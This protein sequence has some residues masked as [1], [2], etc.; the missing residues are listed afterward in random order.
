MQLSSTN[1][2]VS[3]QIIPKFS[4][5][6]AK[7]SDHDVILIHED[8]KIARYSGGR[9]DLIWDQNVS[10]VEDHGS[11]VV[12]AE[13]FNLKDAENGFLK[14]REDIW[15][16]LGISDHRKLQNSHQFRLLAIISHPIASALRPKISLF[17]LS[18]FGDGKDSHK[19]R[20]FEE[21]ST[22]TISSPLTPDSRTGIHYQLDMVSGTLQVLCNGTISSY[23]LAPLIPQK[24]SE[25]RHTDIPLTSF[26]TVSRT[27]LLGVSATHYGSYNT[28]YNSLL[29]S[30]PITK[31]DFLPSRKRKHDDASTTSTLNFVCYFFKLRLAVAVSGHELVGIP[32]DE[33]QKAHKRRK[34]ETLP[35]IDAI[36]KGL[37]SQAPN[38]SPVKSDDLFP[39]LRFPFEDS[40]ILPEYGKDWTDQ[41]GFFNHCVEQGDVDAFEYK[42]A[43]YVGMKAKIIKNKRKRSKDKHAQGVEKSSKVESKKKHILDIVPTGRCEWKFRKARPSRRMPQF[44]TQA[45]YALSKIFKPSTA[46]NNMSL[47]NGS[48][49][50]SGKLHLAFYAPNIFHWLVITGQLT[51]EFINQALRLDQN[52]SSGSTEIS[53]GDLVSAIVEFDPSLGLLYSV[54]NHHLHLDI[55]ML[56]H[57]TKYVIRS[58]DNSI[59]PQSPP[60]PNSNSNTQPPKEKPLTN[61][62]T[63]HVEEEETHELRSE[64]DAAM[65]EVD[66]ALSTLETGL[67]IRAESMRLALS[68]LSTFSKS[69]ITATLRS[70]L[71]QHE[72]ISFI[73][74]LR[75]QLADGGWTARYVDVD[76]EQ[77]DSDEPS[78]RAI[79]VICNLLGCTVDAIGIGGWLMST[80]SD[81][82]DAVDELLA[83]LRGEIATA[84]EGVHEATFM[85]GLLGEFMRYGWIREQA[86]PMSDI[87]NGAKF[88]KVQGDENPDGKILPMGFKVE[89][90]PEKTRVMSGGE[91][92]KRSKRD[93]AREINMA[94]GKYSFE[95]IRM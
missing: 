58:L 49:R 7:D 59:L 2:V 78:N 32:L 43:H 16:R 60:L 54:L 89:K 73:H 13:Q 4:V 15:A 36:G 12:Y 62:I 41:S 74:I 79:S 22:W 92:V 85:S 93:I 66:Y 5:A 30:Q 63:N 50:W 48:S 11:K 31:P 3:I 68:Y 24:S 44:R 28:K 52:S 87:V 84:L 53:S 33:K 56:V 94:V 42:F 45:L 8:W 65:D 23:D 95:E 77:L 38:T 26:L 46:I 88:R 40:A 70:I 14:D 61:G 10:S 90:K 17:A 64:T 1:S 67:P 47:D 57:A 51:P 72:L 81:P 21:L 39:P 9:L 6:R 80:A 25:L 86:E 75:I 18:A 37:P 29:S 83:S 91:V 71:T 34:T 27:Q 69:S 76:L 35:M 19:I 20:K 55:D 82:L